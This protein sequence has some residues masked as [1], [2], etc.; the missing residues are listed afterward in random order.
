MSRTQIF[1][2]AKWNKQE[3]AEQGGVWLITFTDLM[4]LMLTF[5][6][7][8][9]S[10]VDPQEKQWEEFTGSLAPRNGS[11]EG[12]SL[13]RG[14][15]DAIN[16]ARINYSRA[17]DL[18]YLESLIRTLL[19]EEKGLEMIMVSTQSDALVLSIPGR[20]L[21]EAGQADIADEGRKILSLL[22]ETLGRLKNRVE[23]VGHTDAGPVIS[24]AFSSAWELSLARAAAASGILQAQGYGK[25]VLIRGA[26][27]GLYNSLDA[28]LPEIERRTLGNRLD[29]VIME[30]DGKQVTVFDI[31]AP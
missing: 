9:F 22:S 25:P 10:M 28:Q 6:V 27:T 20:Q 1:L 14:P 23:I 8:L 30:D 15:Q 4:A 5:F 16:V 19:A 3:L 17:L 11:F 7:L 13:N 12:Q 31:G 18:T 26:G 2:T 21:F 29:I 24:P